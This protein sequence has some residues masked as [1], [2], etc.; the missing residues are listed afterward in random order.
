VP[1]AADCGGGAPGGYALSLGTGTTRDGR[2]EATWQWDP[3]AL[4]AEQVQRLADGWVNVLSTLADSVERTGVRGL[5][6]S[7]VGLVSLSQADLDELDLN[8]RH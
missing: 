6:P 2:L 8:W 7:D 1:G 4:S 5:T 3:A